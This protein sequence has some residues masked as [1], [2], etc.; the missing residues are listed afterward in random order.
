MVAGNG[1]IGYIK[2]YCGKFDAYQREYVITDFL[3]CNKSLV[4]TAMKRAMPAQI[5]KSTYGSAMPY[6]KL[7]VLTGMLLNIPCDSNEQQMVASF[8][9]Q[10]DT[11]ITL[12]QREHFRHYLN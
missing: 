7:N 2:E 12:H 5:S 1:P 9:Q 11:L 6:I 3:Y 10:F 8:F 4:A